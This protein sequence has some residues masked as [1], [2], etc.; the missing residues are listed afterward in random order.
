MLGIHNAQQVVIINEDSS[1]VHRKI[2]LK[3]VYS[4]VKIKKSVH[5]FS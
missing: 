2:E 4:D 3:V 5:S 1:K